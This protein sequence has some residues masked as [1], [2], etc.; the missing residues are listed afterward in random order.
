MSTEL[1]HADGIG[2][3]YPGM[4]RA[5]LQDIDLRIDAGRHLG[6]IGES[7]S[8]K[9][10][11]T[12]VLLGLQRPTTGTVTYRGERVPAGRGRAARDFRRRVQVV[13]QDPFASLS[14]RMP[15]GR[16]I[17]EPVRALRPE[18][19]ADAR[20]A[21]MLAAVE[22]PADAAQRLP[23]ELSG[24]QR[25]RVAIARALAVRPEVVIADEPVS[26]LDVSVR[27]QVLRLL[28]RLAAHEELTIVAVSH[29]LGII[30]GLCTDALVMTEGRIVERGPV[31]DVLE[32]PTHPY[33]RELIESV[34][35]LPPRPADAPRSTP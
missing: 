30:D 25:Q 7:G 10:T 31:I 9:S 35:L 15:V 1:F 14:P 5:A 29:D 28:R 16:I 20:A 21:E 19:D 17:A 11:L 27:A 22:L 18:W 13:L 6:I 26:A 34:P 12:R 3:T 8:G 4:D 33:T 2:V 23:R 32:N 24:G